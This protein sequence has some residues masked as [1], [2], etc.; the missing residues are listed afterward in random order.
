MVKST[1]RRHSLASAK[2]FPLDPPD[3]AQLHFSPHRSDL[4]FSSSRPSV[5]GLRYTHAIT[6]SFKSRLH[7]TTQAIPSS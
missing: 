7:A 4:F 2:A 1:K 5:E 6:F 3:D